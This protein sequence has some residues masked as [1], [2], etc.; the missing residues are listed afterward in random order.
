MASTDPAR[1]RTTLTALLVLGL[2]AAAAWGG[3]WWTHATVLERELGGAGFDMEPRPVPQATVHTAV[4]FPP[5]SGDGDE[6]LTFRAVELHFAK[7]TAEA[8]ARLSICVPP[9]EFSLIGVVTGP[10]GRHCEE[11]RPLRSGTRMHWVEGF[12]PEEYLVLSIEPERAGVARVDR[13]EIS[14]ARDAAHL[15]Q[16]GT[17]S[18]E[19]NLTMRAARSRQ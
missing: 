8:T 9:D 13:I 14:Y 15:W 17:A 16:R 1:R 2:L 18:A 6:T 12:P 3:W 4:A 11:V 19:V 5:T 7:N 10:L